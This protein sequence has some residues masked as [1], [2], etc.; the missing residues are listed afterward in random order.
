MKH[1]VFFPTL[2]L[3]LGATLGMA[4]NMDGSGL[5]GA[6]DARPRDAAIVDARPDSLP[7]PDA[8]GLATLCTATRGE[9]SES[10]CCA[11]TANFP[12]TCVVGACTCAPNA[13]KS[14]P[15]CTC[16][17]GCFDP[18]FGCVG[19]AATCTLGM[20]QTCNNNPA[21]SSLR[22]HCVTGGRCMCTTGKGLAPSGKCL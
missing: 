7:A 4:C 14:T 20:D 11:N 22:G 8:A 1:A 16:A 3:S 18:L 13:S 2:L 10:K 17:N 21:L 9:I 6:V 15:T 19:P 5:N 12:D